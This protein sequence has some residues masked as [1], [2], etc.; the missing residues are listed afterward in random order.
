MKNDVSDSVTP[1]PRIIGGVTFRFPPALLSGLNVGR[2]RLGLDRILMKAQQ[3]QGPVPFLIIQGNLVS[4]SM[5][6]MNNEMGVL[7]ADGR[8]LAETL[9][10][11]NERRHL[12]RAW[13]AEE[14]DEAFSSQVIGSA[15]AAR[16]APPQRT[17]RGR[18]ASARSVERG[19][20]LTVRGQLTTDA[21]ANAPSDIQWMPPGE[22]TIQP[23]V[24]G[25]ATDEPFI[26]QVVPELAERLDGQLQDMRQKAQNGQGDVPYLDFNHQDQEASGEVTQLYWGGDDPK[27]GGIRAKVIWSDAGKAALE[28]RRYRR[29][30]P[31]WEVDEKTME[32]V[33]LSPNLGGL[34]NRAAFQNIAPIMARSAQ[35]SFRVQGKTIQARTATVMA[36]ARAMAKEDRIPLAT[37]ISHVMQAT[38]GFYEEYRRLVV[39]GR[40]NE[41]HPFGVPRI[42]FGGGTPPRATFSAAA[43]ELNSDYLARGRE[44][45]SATGVSVKQALATLAAGDPGLVERYRTTVM[46]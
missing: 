11:G 6:W 40:G 25:E 44:L 34:V 19:M 2:A 21:P 30:S 13:I 14:T 24:E 22:H 26:I 39:M 15:L 41:R 9:L 42:G 8:P 29:F 5:I 33:G 23:L 10:V 38:P 32:P 18:Q 28:G 27:T 45:A 35:S 17:V 1:S 3:N 20:R 36:Q 12:D 7:M 43:R 16:Y 37:A 46:R 4:L 31:Q